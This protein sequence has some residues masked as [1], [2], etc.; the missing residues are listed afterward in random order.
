MFRLVGA[1][2]VFPQVQDGFESQLFQGLESVVAGLS[3]NGTAPG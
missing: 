2:V 1:A 3:G